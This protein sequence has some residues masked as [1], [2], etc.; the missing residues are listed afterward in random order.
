MGYK[1]TKNGKVQRTYFPKKLTL[2]QQKQLQETPV[3]AA[4]IEKVIHATK[5]IIFTRYSAIA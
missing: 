1:M 5:N 2:T 4:L 3:N